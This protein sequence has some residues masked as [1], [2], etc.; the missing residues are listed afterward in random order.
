MRRVYVSCTYRVENPE[1]YPED[2]GEVFVIDWDA[3]K[4]L[5]VMHAHGPDHV[6]VGRSRGCAGIAWYHGAVWVATR[7]G[8]CIFDPDNYD[9]FEEISFP[10]GGAGTHQVKVHDGKLY[11]VLT[12]MDAFA[13]FEGRSLEKVVH[14]TEED[15]PSTE[16]VG[17][18][19]FRDDIPF[20]SNKLHFN[21]LE[22]DGAGNMY[23]LHMGGCSIFNWSTKKYVAKVK[24]VT[25]HTH[26]LIYHNGKFIVNDSD[27]GTTY[28]VD[29]VSQIPAVVRERPVGRSREGN[30]PGFLRGAALLPGGKSILMSSA[31]GTLT[32]VSLENW[33][34]IDVFD[35]CQNK[36]NAPYD[37]LLDPRDWKVQE[38]GDRNG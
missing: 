16:S 26:D 20:G 7:S 38:E 28:E 10:F 18:L 13:I 15:I 22:W 33:E 9:T 3:K 37:I 23:Q 29:P 5:G 12:S 21:S 30:R 6:A 8:L 11:A 14:I 31:F 34:D 35:F 17:F 1:D 27:S 32:E 4:V 36:S 24:R 25:G 2:I 19:S